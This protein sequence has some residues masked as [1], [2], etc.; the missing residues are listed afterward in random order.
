MTIPKNT[1]KSVVDR[2][3]HKSNNL[4]SQTCTPFPWVPNPGTPCGTAPMRWCLAARRPPESSHAR[5]SWLKPRRLGRCQG[6]VGVTGGL[7]K[8]SSLTFPEPSIGMNEQFWWMHG[9]FLGQFLLYKVSLSRKKIDIDVTTQN[10]I[11][12]MVQGRDCMAMYGITVSR[13]KIAKCLEWSLNWMG[14]QSFRTP[15]LKVW[16]VWHW[17]FCCG[18]LGHRYMQSYQCHAIPASRLRLWNTACKKHALMLPLGFFTAGAKGT[19]FSKTSWMMTEFLCLCRLKPVEYSEFTL[20]I[21]DP[22]VY[23]WVIDVTST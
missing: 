10:A 1:Y 23:R 6:R 20:L 12:R 7:V 16:H 19:F 2:P 14:I 18:P 11:Q 22:R 8:G 5:Q 9:R 21:G 13:P 3:W 17:S 15:K 4:P